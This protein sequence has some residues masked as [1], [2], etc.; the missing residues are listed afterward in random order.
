MSSRQQYAFAVSLPI[1]AFLLAA[2]STGPRPP[3]PGTPAFYWA[4]AREMYRI[5]DYVKANEHL[6]HITRSENEFQARALVWEVVLSAGLTHAYME[7]AD[8]YEMGARV[9]RQNPMPFRRQ[10]NVLR[11]QAGASALQLAEAFQHLQRTVD[12]ETLALDFEFPS[13]NTAPPPELKRV[14]SGILI[15]EAEL[16]MVTRAMTRRGVLLSACRSVG[17][18]GDPAKA[19]DV[20]KTTDPRICRHAFRLSIASQLY[21]AAEVFS[22]TKLD[23]PQR[24]KML[25]QEA[26]PAVQSVPPS[27]DTKDLTRKMKVLLDKHKLTL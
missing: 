27:K 10:T 16:E 1:F 25:L 6:S 22:P 12:D 17:A 8:A 5:G 7:L 15:P 4:A 9:N 24:I 11:R 14:T 13:G 20:F 2:C 26:M 18:G 21:E 23:Q 19:V 3:Q